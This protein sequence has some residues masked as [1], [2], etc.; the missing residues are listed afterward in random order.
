MAQ[1][2]RLKGKVAY[3][4]TDEIKAKISNTL[5]GNTLSEQTKNKISNALKGKPKSPE[6]IEKARQKRLGSKASPE[7]KARLSEI[8]KQRWAKLKLQQ[9]E[10]QK[11]ES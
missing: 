11:N 5:K 2:L 4:M 6:H 1:A 9:I 7:L 10:K 3:V 8:H